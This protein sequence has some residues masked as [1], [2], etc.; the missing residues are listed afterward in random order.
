MNRRRRFDRGIDAVAQNL[1]DGAADFA[2]LRLG[3]AA[4][5]PP[6]GTKPRT[7]A[8][9]PH[10][11]KHK[12]AHAHAHAQ[13]QSTS[14]RAPRRAKTDSLGGTRHTP[15]V[16]QSRRQLER[17]KVHVGRRRV[18]PRRGDGERAQLLATG[19]EQRRHLF[20]FLV[21]VCSSFVASSSRAR[22]RAQKST[23]MFSMD[24]EMLA[25]SLSGSCGAVSESD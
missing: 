19:K 15:A 14:N 17:V 3:K 8:A 24:A 18:S 13:T 12:R 1:V 25:P 2:G 5:T 11:D 21:F 7:R 4:T 6:E 9:R 22:A 16:A 10:T 23:L 20:E